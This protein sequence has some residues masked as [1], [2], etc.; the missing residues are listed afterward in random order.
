MRRQDSENVTILVSNLR[1]TNSDVCQPDAEI[2]SQMTNLKWLFLSALLW[3]SQTQ[4][5]SAL[6]S[7]QTE[8]L[9]RNEGCLGFPKN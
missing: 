7:L 2:Y 9:R 4:T 3:M 1:M 5:V 6:T 8:L